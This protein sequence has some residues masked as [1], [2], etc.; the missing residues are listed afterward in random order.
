MI[1]EYQKP[2]ALLY[3]RN[4][5]GGPDYFAMYISNTSMLGIVV[6][7]HS[8]V[9]PLN[10]DDLERLKAELC[11]KG[12]DVVDAGSVNPQS[13]PDMFPRAIGDYL[14][15]KFAGEYI[16]DIKIDVDDLT[17]A[18]LPEAECLKYLSSL[19]GRMRDA[20]DDDILLGQLE[21]EMKTL[22]RDPRLQKYEINELILAA[23]LPIKE[24]EG[25]ASLYLDKFFAVHNERYEDAQTIQNRINSAKEN[26]CI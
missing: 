2:N 22:E 24:G 17:Y 5:T 26:S 20:L 18:L 25:L 4:E 14:K 12:S 19:T 10:R 1:E 9:M 7:I 21:R 3:W 16:P 6:P 13:N 23:K 8:P 11:E 15:R